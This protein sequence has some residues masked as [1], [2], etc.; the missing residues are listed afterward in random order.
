MKECIGEKYFYNNSFVRCDNFNENV[1]FKGKSIYEVLRVIDGIYLFVED[2]LERL[3]YFNQLAGYSY[4]LNR[5]NLLDN[6]KKLQTENGIYSGNVKI[7]FNFYENQKN[8]LPVVLAYF[9][10]HNYPDSLQYDHGVALLLTYIVRKN[11]NAKI[12]NKELIKTREKTLGNKSFF[13]ILLVSEK[14]YITEASKANVFFIK[15]SILYTPPSDQVLEGITRKYVLIISEQLGIPVRVEKI[16][17]NELEHFEG[18][19]LTGTSPKVLP[20][21]L[22]DNIN[23]NVK[24]VNIQRIKNKYNSLIIE[25]IKKNKYS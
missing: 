16:H 3:Q 9:I 22:I 25:Y 23:Y 4:N 24:E 19:F 18:C 7:V 20:V 21:S 6:L 2:H 11:P 15:N 13:E 17:K 14:G 5:E 10:Q 8:C 12:L 1:L